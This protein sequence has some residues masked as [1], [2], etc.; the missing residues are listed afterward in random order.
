MCGFAYGVF[1]LM[2]IT[3]EGIASPKEFL[4]HM[5][6]KG[7]PILGIGYRIKSLL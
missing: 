5:K 4:G 1:L 7:I 3:V 2:M 6:K